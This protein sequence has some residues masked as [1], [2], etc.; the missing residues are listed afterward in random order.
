MKKIIISAALITGFVAP[1]IFTAA[2]YIAYG[3]ENLSS[4]YATWSESN[5]RITNSVKYCMKWVV[6][7]FNKEKKEISDSYKQSI[8]AVVKKS[9]NRWTI[10]WEQRKSVDQLQSIRKEYTDKLTYLKESSIAKQRNCL[11]N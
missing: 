5:N 4:G 2:Q 10:S 3:Q 7:E 6:R 8:K 11:Q 1:A 9:E